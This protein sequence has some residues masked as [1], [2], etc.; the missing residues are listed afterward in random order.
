MDNALAFSFAL[1]PHIRTTLTPLEVASILIKYF[2]RE[3]FSLHLKWPNDLLNS[4]GQKCGGILCTFLT[5]ETIIVGIGLNWGRADFKDIAM[6]GS[7][8]DQR[9]LSEQ[10]KENIPLAIYHY[11][12]KNRISSQQI[13][14]TWSRHCYHQGKSVRIVDEDAEASGVFQ[15]ITVD[16]EAIIEDGGGESRHVT[17]GSLIIR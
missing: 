2:Q 1:K 14:Q 4:Q 10:D 3:Q 15:G 16:G 13:L 6:S 12:L 7:I 9:T 5:E 17:A 11:I 8:D